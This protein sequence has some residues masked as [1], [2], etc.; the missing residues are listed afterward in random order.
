VQPIRLYDSQTPIDLATFTGTRQALLNVTKGSKVICTT[1]VTAID[2][3]AVLTVLIENSYNATD[4]FDQLASQSFN[5]SGRTKN[6]FT[7]F[8]SIF[9][10]TC[11]VTGG[12][13]TFKVAVLATEGAGGGSGTGGGTIVLNDALTINGTLQVS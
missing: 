2:P 1:D 13:A 6:V 3:G 9:R 10:I 11:T 7:D 4:A 8:N 12:N 5:A